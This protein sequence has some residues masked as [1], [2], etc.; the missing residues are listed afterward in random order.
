VDKNTNF[1]IGVKCVVNAVVLVN[2]FTCVDLDGRGGQE[3]RFSYRCEMCD[4]C[5]S[6]SEEFHLCASGRKRWTRILIFVSV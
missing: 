1:R 5:S 6:A 3:Y 2:S 4:K